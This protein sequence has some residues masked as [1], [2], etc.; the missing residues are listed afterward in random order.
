MYKRY[1]SLFF[2]CAIEDTDNELLTLEVIHRFV[3]ILDKYFGSVC[4]LDIIFNFEKA[5]FILDEFLMAGEIQ[6]SS[7]SKV[8]RAVEHSDSLQEEN[9]E[10]EATRSIL[11]EFGLT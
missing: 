10:A 3:E 4:E 8:L 6:E 7:K 9:Q 11:E 2:C 1:A 5:Y